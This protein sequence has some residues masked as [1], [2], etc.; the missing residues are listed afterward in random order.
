MRFR[1]SLLL[2]VLV[3]FAQASVRINEFMADNGE[4]L[5][6]SAGEASDW[7]ELYNSSSEPVD[8]SGW[9]LTDSI[10]KPTKWQFPEGVI[11]PADSYLIVFADSSDESWVDGE[12]HSNFSLSKSGEYLGLIMPD[13]ETVV[14]EYA[15]EFPPQLEDISYGVASKNVTLVDRNSPMRYRSATPQ[16]DAE[17]QVGAGGLGFSSQNGTFEVKFYRMNS[18]I[19]NVDSAEQ[20]IANPSKWYSSNYPVV[21]NYETI[22]F[23]ESETQCNFP[24]FVPFPSLKINEN[25]NYFVVTAESTVYIPEA[26][27]WSFSVG[28]DDGFRL[29]LSGNGYNFLSEFPNPRAFSTTISQFN[30]PVAGFYKLDLIF[31]E[32]TGGAAL[33]LSVAKGAHSGFSLSHFKLL[34]DPGCEIIHAGAINAYCDV[35]MFDEMVGN[36]ARLDVEWDFELDSLPGSGDQLLLSLYIADGF[37]AYLNNEKI[38]ELNAPENLFHDSTA[39]K[40]RTNIEAI[41]PFLLTLP[42]SCLLEGANTLFI[43]ALNDDKED[44]EFLIQ[45]E[46]NLLSEQLYAGYFSNPTPG[47]FNGNFSTPPTPVVVVDESRGY[48]TSSFHATMSCPEDP[49]AEI[50]FT[51]DGS[52]PTLE[53]PIYSEPLY[54]DKTTTLRAAVVMPDS[55][56]QRVSTFTWLF[57]EDILQQSSATPA[58]WPADRA[59]NNHSMLYGMN[60]SIINGDPVRIRQGMTNAI[61]SIS[62]VTDLDNMFHPQTGVYVNPGVFGMENPVSVELIDPA[63]GVEKEFQIDAGIRIRGAYSRSSSNPKHSLRLFFR[64]KYGDSKL[65]FPLFDEEG[66]DSFDRVDLRTAQNYNWS[67]ENNSKNTMVREVF[68]RDAQREMGVPYTRSR[69]YH[70]YINGIYWGIYQTQERGDARFAA[71]YM[72]GD[73]D[74]WDCIKT[75]QPGYV[76]EVNSGNDEAFNAFHAIAINEGFSGPNADNYWRVRGMNP[77]G[78]PNPDYPVYLDEDNLICYIL[79]Y[80]L[81]GDPDSP[82]GLSGEI[83]NN[84][85]ALYNRKNPDGF[86]WLRHDAEHSLGAHGGYPATKDIIKRG[87]NLTQQKHF[88]PATLHIRLM[89]HPVYRRRFADLVQKFL[90]NDGP[91]SPENSQALFRSRM[92]M[93]DQAIVAESARWG[94]GK[95]RADHWLPACNWVIN[96]YLNQRRDILVGQLRGYGWFPSTQSPLLSKPDGIVEKGKTLKIGAERTFYFTTDG[97]DP[98]LAD[99]SINPNAIIVNT[100]QP[101]T[102]P[103][104][105]I[106]RGA[107]WS[108]YDL[109]QEPAVQ[110]SKTWRDLDY[111][112]SSWAQGPAILGIAS[113]ATVNPV[114]T[115]TRRYVTGNSGTQVATT[116]FRHTFTPSSTTDISSLA[117]ELLRDDGAVLYL[118]GTEILRDNMPEGPITYSTWSS[119]IVGSPEQ[120]TYFDFNLQLAHLLREG[121]NVL[122]AEIHQCHGTSTDL[123][124]DMKL[125]A[126]PP[127]HDSMPYNTT[128]ILD[129]S[130]TIKARALS[131]NEWSPLAEGIYTIVMPENY[132]KGIRVSEMMYAP[133]KPPKGTSLY[134]NDDFAWL[135]LRNIGTWPVDLDGVQF[136]EGIEHVFA[137]AILNPGERLVVAKNPVALDERSPVADIN[138]VAWTKGNLARKG[139]TLA[140]TD[141]EGDNILTF[142][143]SNEWYP[144]TYNTDYTIVAVDLQADEPLWSTAAN[145]RPGKFV[146]G[147]PG[148]P[149]APVFSSIDIGNNGKTCTISIEGIDGNP[150]LLWSTDLINWSPCPAEACI[151]TVD[152]ITI[153][154]LD[155]TFNDISKCFFKLQVF[156]EE[157]DED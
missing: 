147:S 61:A 90:C 83:V 78:S 102:Q 16:N 2:C 154:L 4:S 86:K 30:I 9:H 93:I 114:A 143:Y 69:Y 31:Y 104:T 73:K 136:T 7:I 71:T 106:S 119:H 81:T 130:M 41:T 129:E 120:N 85:Y 38:A 65:N 121:E 123:Y 29:R 135:E 95:T 105:L 151:Y 5:L 51:L 1:I 150:Q 28:S 107:T 50:R 56:W 15:P 24:N 89:E 137:P 144:E 118:N 131:N 99:G 109:G 79:S 26:G 87:A 84:M 36:V 76:T 140:L 97:S 25:I 113:S 60:Q 32:R 152:A 23:Y 68:S 108:Y 22:N 33:E 17:W 127:P 11:I 64:S 141:P 122:A 58:G 35:N 44:G 132:Y 10:N 45:A 145:W 103:Q 43:A 128:V 134:E 153:D 37:V 52:T 19:A 3:G 157:Y 55:V 34:G 138:I 156:D 148:R 88:N 62:L 6:T 63:R 155:E 101:G 42:A 117:I 14:H 48:K 12:L 139:E 67:W 49:A 115:T 112:D 110:G 18:D 70:L 142:T 20:M 125:V 80:Y 39:S 46:L 74:D 54:V 40:K 27:I 57:L 149:E 111:N 92:D 13:G 47:A 100:A 133:T 75:S 116:Y 124:F 72:G 94:R 8:L 59:V 66:A 53:S 126:M 91:L 146:H 96:N 98:C 77:D 82:I 21:G